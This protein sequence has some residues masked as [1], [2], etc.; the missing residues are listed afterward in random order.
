MTPNLD[1]VYRDFDSSAAL[2]HTINEKYQKLSKFSDDIMH[3]RVVVDAPHKHKGKGRRFRASLELNLKG[4]PLKISHDD[5][6]VHVAVRDLF[7]A[8]ERKLKAVVNKK[9]AN[10]FH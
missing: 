10:R 4:T 7:V 9:R 1:V 3:S 8:A 5:E 2:T 6:S